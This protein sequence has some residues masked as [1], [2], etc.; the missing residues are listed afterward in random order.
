MPFRYLLMAIACVTGIAQAH[1]FEQ[2]T[3]L[4]EHSLS[5]CS[6]SKLEKYIFDLGDAALYRQDCNADKNVLTDSPVYVEFAYKRS[7]EGKDF[8]ETA[9]KLISRNISEQ[10]FQ[11]IAADLN[12]FNKAYKSIE[13]GDRYTIAYSQQSGLVLSLNGEVLTRSDNQQ[14]AQHYFTIWFGDKPFSNQLKDNLLGN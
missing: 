4:A 8:A 11:K 9:E 7:L 5:K 13:D 6:E 1:E 12:A 3:K 2:I 14:L 10:T